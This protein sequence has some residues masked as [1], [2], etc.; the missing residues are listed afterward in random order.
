MQHMSILIYNYASARVR[1]CIS[2]DQVSEFRFYNISLNLIIIHGLFIKFAKEPKQ[3]SFLVS[4]FLRRFPGF[5]PGLHR[6]IYKPV[7]SVKTSLNSPDFTSI[8]HHFS[9]SVC[10]NIFLGT[11]VPKSEPNKRKGVQNGR[12]RARGIMWKGFFY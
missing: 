5:N 3:K 1:V 12:K 4:V 7:K 2:L 8:F 10:A 11:K 6:F 9:Q